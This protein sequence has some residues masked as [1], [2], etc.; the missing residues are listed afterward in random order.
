VWQKYIQVYVNGIMSSDTL[1]E[2]IKIY[3]LVTPIHYENGG[4]LLIFL[5]SNKTLPLVTAHE[6]PH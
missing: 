5:S 1:A 3:I 4:V 6:N 2:V